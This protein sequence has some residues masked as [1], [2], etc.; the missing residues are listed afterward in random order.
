MFL[1]LG[2]SRLVYECGI[3]L[4]FSVFLFMKKLSVFEW[5]VN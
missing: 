3:G 5:I 1:Y 4:L 2:F